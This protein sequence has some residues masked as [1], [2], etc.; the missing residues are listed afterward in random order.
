MNRSI[1]V[2]VTATLSL[3]CT[4]LGP[5]AGATLNN[6]VPQDR[7]G[8]E[9]QGATVPGW[10]VSDT[11]KEQE[12]GGSVTQLAVMVD[13]GK[14]LP[15]KGLG[16]GGRWVGSFDGGYF[17]P[18]IRYRTFL[19]EG[20]R[21]ALGLTGYAT[22]ASGSERG[23]S[24]EM[25]R[26]GV[27]LGVDVRVTPKNRWAELHVT[28][29]ASVTGVTADGTYC[30]NEAGYGRDCDSDTNE[31]GDTTGQVSG[32]FPAAFAGVS[33]DLFRGIPVLHFLR[34]GAY[35]AGG[36][37]PHARFN[38]EEPSRAWFAYGLNLTAGIGAF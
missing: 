25:T 11:V 31:Q 32:A 17:E 8:V 7:A 37:M 5:M 36:A 21:V 12:S 28:G 9:L 3:G 19:D 34:L 16:I 23:A 4:Q 15:T 18:M 20:E 24:Y 14:L 30:M 1:I 35:M 33:L 38:K 2:I 10:H 29:G 22:H 6:V 26:G 27:E 13:A